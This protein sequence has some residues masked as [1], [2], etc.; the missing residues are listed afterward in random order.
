[1]D[2]SRESPGG[3][4]SRKVPARARVAFAN[5]ILVVVMPPFNPGRRTM[6]RGRSGPSGPDGVRTGPARDAVRRPRQ[7]PGAGLSARGYGAV[8]RQ[9]QRVPHAGFL[10]VAQ[11]PRGAGGG[12]L[13]EEGFD[14]ARPTVDGLPM[15]GA[16]AL[17]EGRCGLRLLLLPSLDCRSANGAGRHGDAG[18]AKDGLFLFDGEHD[19]LLPVPIRPFPDLATALSAFLDSRCRAASAVFRQRVEAADVKR[20]ALRRRGARRLRGPRVSLRAPAFALIPLGPVALPDVYPLHQP[21]DRMFSQ[22]TTKQIKR[23]L[24]AGASTCRRGSGKGDRCRSK[25][26]A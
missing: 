16:R 21:G 8:R 23:L 18:L 24:E 9:A 17:P 12:V 11:A 19:R 20:P 1:M 4:R 3:G 22:V 13:D 5:I 25:R 10:G 6:V 14:A 7:W 15:F 26:L 2:G